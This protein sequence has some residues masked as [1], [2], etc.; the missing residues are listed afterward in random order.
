VLCTLLGAGARADEARS[1]REP[2]AVQPFTSGKASGKPFAHLETGLPAFVAERL[3]QLAPLRFVGG[4]AIFDAAPAT[5]KWI[6]DGSFER[7]ADWRLEVRV[8]VH[9]AA[10]DGPSAEAVRIGP[11][12]AAPRLA[13]DAALVAFAALPGV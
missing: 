1:A 5:A 8:K 12:D 3:A 6:V 2:F 7:Q 13:L 10:A 4:P 9:G 11:K